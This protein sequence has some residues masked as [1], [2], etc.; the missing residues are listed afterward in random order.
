M[1]EFSD[2]DDRAV[3]RKREKT[4]DSKNNININIER[5]DYSNINFDSLT[6]RDGDPV[7]AARVALFLFDCKIPV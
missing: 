2:L 1:I 4:N 7:G 3:R 5:S 6:W